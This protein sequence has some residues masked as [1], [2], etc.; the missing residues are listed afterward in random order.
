MDIYNRKPSVLDH[1]AYFLK[2]SKMC[3]D[4]SHHWCGDAIFKIFSCFLYFTARH[5]CGFRIFRLQLNWK[6]SSP[7]HVVI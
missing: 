5:Y 4:T 6:K 1:T 2:I 3:S 7:M